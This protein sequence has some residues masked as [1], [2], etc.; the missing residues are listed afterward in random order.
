MS[1]ALEKGQV[2]FLTHASNL[3]TCSSKIDARA[4][5]KQGYFF[6]WPSFNRHG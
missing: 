3:F 2:Y 1:A 4:I 5:E 6:L